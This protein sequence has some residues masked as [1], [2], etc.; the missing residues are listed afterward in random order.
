MQCRS[1]KSIAR[2]TRQTDSPSVHFYHIVDA[3]LIGHSEKLVMAQEYL[4][5]RTK[6]INL[7]FLNGTLPFSCKRAD[8]T[9]IQ[10]ICP[11]LKAL[12]CPLAPF[13][14]LF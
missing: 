7:S 10:C 2:A 1:F 5:G 12:I 9:V 8:K 4:N 3:V 6:E 14:S 13:Y 11:Y